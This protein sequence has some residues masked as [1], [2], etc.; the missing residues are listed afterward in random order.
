MQ[1]LNIPE[2]SEVVG[3]L[4]SEGLLCTIS[5][6]LLEKVNAGVAVYA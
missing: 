2:L 6:G 1:S 5:M 4:M 3:N